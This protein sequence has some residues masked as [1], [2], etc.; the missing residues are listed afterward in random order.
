[1]FKE[2]ANLFSK[3]T[4]SIPE[5]IDKIFKT[6]FSESSFGNINNAL[7]SENQKLKENLAIELSHRK[8]LEEKID[9]LSSE[10]QKIEQQQRNFLE[11]SEQKSNTFIATINSLK[12]YCKQQN[13]NIQSDQEQY[14]NIISK[15]LKE[16]NS[17]IVALNAELEKFDQLKDSLITDKEKLTSKITELEDEITKLKNIIAK[18]EEESITLKSSLKQLLKL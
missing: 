1:M 16:T 14:K 3:N 7:E 8:E 2:S 13:N 9:R 6:E 10:K 4:V 11:I 15:I 5:E 12:Q 17:K 18:Q